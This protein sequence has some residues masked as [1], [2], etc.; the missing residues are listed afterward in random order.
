MTEWWN[1]EIA[2]WH[3]VRY[4]IVWNQDTESTQM[5]SWQSPSR[6]VYKNKEKKDSK[7]RGHLKKLLRKKE[8]YPI[9][10][11]LTIWGD[12]KDDNQ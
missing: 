8:S 6:L 7:T 9:G 4:E 12:K 1:G 2:G 3:N 5:P 10:L 11:P